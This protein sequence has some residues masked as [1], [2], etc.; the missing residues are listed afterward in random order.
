[1]LPGAVRYRADSCGVEMRKALLNLQL[2]LYR[3]VSATTFKHAVQE[4]I[5]PCF[6]AHKR[7]LINALEAICLLPSFKASLIPYAQPP[8]R[9]LHLTGPYHPLAWKA[10]IALQ[11]WALLSPCKSHTGVLPSISYSRVSACLQDLIAW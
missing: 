8:A 1:M 10:Q 3:G 4:V 5:K 7:N 6:S 2:S 11:L 9:C